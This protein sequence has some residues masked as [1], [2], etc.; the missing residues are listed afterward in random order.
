MSVGS[1]GPFVNFRCLKNRQPSCM[2]RPR[3]CMHI[4][5]KF[6]SRTSTRTTTMRAKTN[7]FLL[8]PTFSRL[9][10]ASSIHRLPLPKTSFATT[11]TSKMST[12]PAPGHKDAVYHTECTGKALDTVKAHSSPSELTLFGACFCPF[13]HR[14]WIALEHVGGESDATRS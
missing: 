2:S 14:V 5:L 11:A 13:V 12:K 1:N 4:Q 8:T 6:K 7:F 10:K 3:P 9:N